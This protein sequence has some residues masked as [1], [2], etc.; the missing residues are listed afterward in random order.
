MTHLLSP[1][2]FLILKTGGGGVI[3]KWKSQVL[4]ATARRS[5]MN[6]I[7]YDEGPFPFSQIQAS[8]EKDSGRTNK[9]MMGSF[10]QM[11]IE[12]QKEKDYKVSWREPTD[13][14]L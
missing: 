1:T 10:F 3:S 14:A 5:N 8:N 12:S 4:S 7:L 9:N 13:I 6:C 2:S 11:Q